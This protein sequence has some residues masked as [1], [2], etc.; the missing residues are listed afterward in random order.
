[1]E[2]IQNFF[3]N[4]LLIA[5]FIFLLKMKDEITLSL[6]GVEKLIELVKQDSWEHPQAMLKETAIRF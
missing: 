4:T 1:M 3:S 6:N 2:L 5:I